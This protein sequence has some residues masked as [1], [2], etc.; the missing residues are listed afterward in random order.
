MNWQIV[1]RDTVLNRSGHDP[2]LVH[3]PGPAAIWLASEAGWGVLQPDEQQRVGATLSGRADHA[4]RGKAAQ[5]RRQRGIGAP[6]DPRRRQRQRHG[7]QGAEQ[8]EQHRG[9]QIGAEYGARDT[10]RANG[11]L[12]TSF[13]AS[14]FGIGGGYTRTDGISSAATAVKPTHRSV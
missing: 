1:D 11:Q 2:Y 3:E 6:Q 5:G 10:V 14:Q 8:L 12:R 4:R 9:G 13:G 7:G